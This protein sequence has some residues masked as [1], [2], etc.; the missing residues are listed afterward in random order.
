[1]GGAVHPFPNTPSWRG[2]QGE[3][4]DNFAFTFYFV[5]VLHQCGVARIRPSQFSVDMTDTPEIKAT[6]ASVQGF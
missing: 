5:F 1:M 3:H 6:P 4:R 2:A